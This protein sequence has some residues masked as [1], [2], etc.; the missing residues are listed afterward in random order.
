M[1]PTREASIYPTVQVI[2]FPKDAEEGEPEVFIEV[3]RLSGDQWE[4]RIDPVTVIPD[5][6]PSRPS[7]VLRLNRS[8]AW[9]FETM[10]EAL[11]QGAALAERVHGWTVEHRALIGRLDGALRLDPSLRVES[12]A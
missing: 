1:S 8:R 11:L 6:D 10:E 4:I 2:V 12:D 7:E 3:L 5:A 9:R